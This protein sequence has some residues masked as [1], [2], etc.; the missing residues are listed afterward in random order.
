MEAAR[1]AKTIVADVSTLNFNL[2]FEV[3]FAI[4]LG[5]PVIP[6]RDSNYVQDKR[7]FEELGVLDT[8]GYLDFRN[9]VDL[10]VSLA[11]KLPGAAFPRLPAKF[12]DEQ[13][14]YILK[15]RVDTEGRYA[16]FLP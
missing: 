3:G 8:V 6:F 4:G 2:M 12:F 10:A 5:L 1:S 11:A 9:S 13:P 7:A 16:Y 14:L 15:G